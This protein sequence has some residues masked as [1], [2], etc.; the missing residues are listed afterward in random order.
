MVGIYGAAMRVAMLVGFILFAFN[1]IV[2]PKFAALYGQKDFEA[3]SALARDTAGLMTLLAAPVLLIFMVVPTWILGLFG[4]EFTT[5]AMVLTILTIGQ[6]INVATGSAGN[7]LIM[8]GNEKLMRNT[9]VFSTLLNIVLNTVLI[10]KFGIIGAALAHAIT[11]ATM[12]I[13]Q[14][15]LVYRKLSIFIIP[16]PKWIFNHAK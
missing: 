9:T 8:T 16:V 4:P 5:G 6:F 14:V 3:L 13:I 11:L 15:F 1:T 7:L 2:T 10:L 12:K